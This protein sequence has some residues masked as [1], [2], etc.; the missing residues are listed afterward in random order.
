MNSDRH[1]HHERANRTVNAQNPSPN[2]SPT[3]RYVHILGTA[4]RWHVIAWDASP[5][6]SATRTKSREAAAGA[7]PIT[8]L[9]SCRRF[10]TPFAYR[11]LS[12][13]LRPRLSPAVASRL[14][15]CTNLSPLCPKWPPIYVKT[16]R[17]VAFGSNL[18][19]RGLFCADRCK[20]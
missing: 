2:K 7:G 3:L 1:R 6:F 15:M 8:V 20:L 11:L 9:P 16:K 13:D 5:R 10:A 14:K 4:K 12:W 19:E 18:R 17:A